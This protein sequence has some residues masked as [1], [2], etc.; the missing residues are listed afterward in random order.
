MRRKIARASAVVNQN[1]PV[2]TIVVDA[3]RSPR[4]RSAAMGNPV[5]VPITNGTAQ[6]PASTDA[7]KR[8]LPIIMTHSA[9]RSYECPMRYKLA[10]VLKY[11]SKKIARALSLGLAAHKAIELFWTAIRDGAKDPLAC[12]LSGLNELQGFDLALIRPMIIAYVAAWSFHKWTVLAIEKKFSLALTHPD[13]RVH[14]DHLV[15]GRIDLILRGPDGIVKLIDHKTSGVDVSEGSSYRK[16]LARDEQMSIYMDGATSLGYD[17]GRIVYDVLKKPRIKPK[18]ATPEEKRKMVKDKATGE[19]R[20]D[21]RQRD[22]DETPDE[23]EYRV[24]MKIAESPSDYI[25][26][27]PLERTK[28][29]LDEMRANLWNQAHHIEQDLENDHFASRSWLCRSNG[30]ECQFLPF[31]E[32]GKS[33]NDPYLFNQI[34]VQHPELEEDVEIDG[35][36]DGEADPD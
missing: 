24:A 6:L 11:R 19:M 13:G 5:S 34:G 21:K 25:V 15:E 35:F 17:I 32:E 20:L 30:M 10:Y 7:P 2:D 18:I 8:F 1:R 9:L 26:R 31:C 28:E 33:L 4:V 3:H 23:F 16:R 36:D 14:P 29:Q 12:A 22:R 27:I